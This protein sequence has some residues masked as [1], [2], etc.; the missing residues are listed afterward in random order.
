MARS[1]TH[2][3][4]RD[5]LVRPQPRV[6]FLSYD[7]RD[8]ERAHR[9]LLRHAAM[10]GDVRTVGVAPGDPLGTFADDSAIIDEICRRYLSDASVGIVL[11][12]AST[13]TR[14]F[15]DWEIAAAA[16]H[17]CAL[18]ALPLEFA[19]C[20][21]PTRLMLLAEARRAAVRTRPPTDSYELDSWIHTAMADAASPGRTARVVDMPLMRHDATAGS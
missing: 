4:G 8:S 16:S 11:L 3:D 20:P 6:T 17:G 21:I 5:S 7:P 10:L 1:G 18:L 9:F 14:R 15:V 13:W 19:A 12:G 2:A